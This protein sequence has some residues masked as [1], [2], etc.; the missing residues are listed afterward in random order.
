MLEEH[1]FLGSSGPVG[2]MK[3]RTDG[4]L[5]NCG[6][7]GCWVTEV[8][9]PA[10]ARKVEKEYIDIAGIRNGDEALLKVLDEIAEML[11]HGIANLVNLF[12]LDSIILGG[13]MLPLLPYMLDKTR[14][15]VE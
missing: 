9:L 7:H 15:T 13:A 6:D 10:L 8:S 14:A 3:I 2:H 4:A 1:L 12:N 11:G 5:C